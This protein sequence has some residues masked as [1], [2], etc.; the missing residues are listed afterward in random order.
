MTL[1][2]VLITGCSEGGIGH[3]TA[4]AFAATNRYHIFATARSLSKMS[5]LAK[6]K[7]VTCLELDV[8]STASISACAKAV[9][10]HTDG[11]LDVLVNNAGQVWL[12]PALDTD[13]EQVRKLFDVNFWGVVNVTNAFARMVVKSRGIIATTGSISGDVN[14]P[15]AS[16][17]AATKSAIM[18]Y[19]ETLR[20]E[21]AP[22]GV[23]V[24][25]MATGGVVSNIG[26][27]LPDLPDDSL[28]K[29][30]EEHLREKLKNPGGGSRMPTKEYAEK[31]VKV[32]ESGKSGKVYLGAGAGFVKW[33]KLVLPTVVI[34]R[35]VSAGLGLERLKM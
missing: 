31:F 17:Y 20:L 24:L 22:F 11:K 15:M 16:F 21:L 4:L 5:S 7:N 35:L 34:D 27:G 2:A 19:S 32:V 9:A 23:K 1:K 33:G 29:S 10:E 8:T 3:A 13:V 25:T 30:L 18:T 28:Y 6:A 14:S 12:G 26:S